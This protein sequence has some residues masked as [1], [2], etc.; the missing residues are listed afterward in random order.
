MHY[1]LNSEK[2][3]DID[4]LAKRIDSLKKQLKIAL[5][6]NNQKVVAFIKQELA[7]KKKMLSV[8][9]QAE[10]AFDDAG[11]YQLKN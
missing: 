5:R 1:D 2:Q 4:R 3:V 9:S 10:V 6:C 7:S 11:F 8:I